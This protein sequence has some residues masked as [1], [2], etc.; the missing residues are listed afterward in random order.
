LDDKRIKA[1]ACNI[2]GPLDDRVGEPGFDANLAA[3]LGRALATE[4][5]RQIMV[6]S[7]ASGRT[8]G[9]LNVTSAL[10]STADDASPTAQE[11]ITK[12]GSAYASIAGSSGQGVSDLDRGRRLASDLLRPRPLH[13]IGSSQRNAP[14]SGRRAQRCPRQG[15]VMHRSPSAESPAPR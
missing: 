8:L 6:G 11:I 12:L 3:D 1:L 10:S 14:G 15:S 7:N 5:E 2:L 13:G 9:L 4:R